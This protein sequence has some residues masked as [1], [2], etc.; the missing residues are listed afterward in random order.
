PNVII[1]RRPC[2]LLK[3]VKHQ[4]PITVDTEKC[5]GCKSCMQIGCPAIAVIGGKA[6]IDTTLCVG[7]DVCTQ[8]CRFSAL[9][10][11]EGRDA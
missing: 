7:C 4:S 6:R 2:A 5:V 9:V 3:N 1:S 10:R 11:P 8:M